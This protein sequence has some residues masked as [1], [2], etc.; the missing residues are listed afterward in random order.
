MITLSTR[1]AAILERRSEEIVLN[2]QMLT[3]LKLQIESKDYSPFNR[4][5][6]VVIFVLLQR[7]LLLYYSLESW[8]DLMNGRPQECVSA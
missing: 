8:G 2:L 6:N 4:P 5:S 3:F 7:A 1:M